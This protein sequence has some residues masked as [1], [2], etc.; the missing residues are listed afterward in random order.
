MALGAFYRRPQAR[1]G[2]PQAII[3]AAHKLARLVYT[4]WKHARAYV[5]PTL[6]E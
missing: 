6:D 3:A 2:A 5:A 4:L 1:L